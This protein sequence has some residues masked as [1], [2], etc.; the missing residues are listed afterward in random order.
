MRPLA[1]FAFLALAALVAS[2]ALA[3]KTDDHLR[4][5]PASDG[6][7]G[8][9][10]IADAIEVILPFFDHGATCDNLDDHDEICPYAGSTS[11]DVVYT[12]TVASGMLTDVD[13]CGS[14]YDT[15]VYLYDG[16]L[17]LVA[18]N[19][20]FYFGDPCGMYV[21]KLENVYLEGGETYFLVIDGYGGDC[22]E[23]VVSAG[24]EIPPCIGARCDDEMTPEGEP[25]FGEGYV[26]THNGGCD[27]D[28][29]AFQELV[30][31]PGEQSLEFC[32]TTGWYESGGP[33]RDSDW[34]VAVAAGELIRIEAEGPL[35][36]IVELDVLDLQ[37][38]ENISL[39]PYEMGYC[40]D[41]VVDIPTTPGE[42]VFFRVRPQAMTRP[43]C[44][45]MVE[46]YTLSITGIDGPVAVESTTWSAL[47]ELYR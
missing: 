20:D 18:C 36:A 22:G 35:F 26:D 8:G 42:V 15:K 3:D 37:D 21:S 43:M 1:P 23:Y 13:L 19:D 31:P 41:A 7:E 47:R 38:C 27:V 5:R 44:A 29:P 11:P 39:L 4:A 2:P 34:Y 45:D 32:G 12:F 33:Q 14:G 6:R 40:L 28:P 9:E 25:P 46:E 17:N 16:D 24:C 30:L 10:S